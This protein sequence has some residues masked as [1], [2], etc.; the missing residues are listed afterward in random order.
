MRVLVQHRSRY[1]YPQPAL[2]GP[3]LIRLRPA[4]HARAR[5]ESYRLE[6]SPEHRLHWQR[7][8]HGN[9]VARVTFKAG[10]TI[11]ALEIVVE[12]AVDINPVNPFDFFVDD[13]AK[14]IP[15]TYPDDL[16][17]ELAA[18]LDTTD[19]AYRL[20]RRAIELLEKV[21]Q[22]GRGSCRDSAVLLV[23]L[24]RARGIA[25]RFVSGYLIQLTDE[26]M[27]P[28]EPKG[29]SRDVVDLHLLDR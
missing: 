6:V 26:G 7:D 17:G 22:I 27:I 16:G 14:K 5:I 10:Q 8:P 12:L 13:R 29:V 15:F 11:E 1:G 20:G 9:R 28:N 3:Q 23:A 24:L 19:P 25:A 18:F 21:R 2:L 4:D